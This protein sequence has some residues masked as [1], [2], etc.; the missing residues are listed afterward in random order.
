MKHRIK[1][2]ILFL[3]ASLVA[4]A[5]E[6]G[7]IARLGMVCRA[8][9]RLLAAL[10]LLAFVPIGNASA[11]EI[12]FV[13]VVGSWHDPVDTDPGSQPGDPVITN[14]NPTSSISWGTTAGSQSGYDFIATLP[15]PFTLPGPIP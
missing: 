10:A 11:A 1:I 9:V 6:T 8:G 4:Q 13:S 3:F 7:V 15:P 12:T 5:N 14:G 2:L